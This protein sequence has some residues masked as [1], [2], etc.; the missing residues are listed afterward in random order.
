MKKLKIKAFGEEVPVYLAIS[1]YCTNGNLAVLIMYDE[2][3]CEEEW[4]RLSVN[5]LPLEENAIAVDVNNNHGNNVI[6]TLEK[7]GV[8]TPLR[9]SLPSGYYNCDYPVYSV[10]LEKAKEY[11]RRRNNDYLRSKWNVL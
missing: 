8:I 5:I 6:E 1:K 9:Y 4:G 7:L 10:N 3:G 11:T 2:E